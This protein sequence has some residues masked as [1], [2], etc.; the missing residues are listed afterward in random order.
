MKYQLDAQETFIEDS[1]FPKGQEV[2]SGGLE[3]SRL[4]LQLVSLL[5]S[6]TRSELLDKYISM[7]FDSIYNKLKFDIMQFYIYEILYEMK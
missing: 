2:S 5:L 1:L 3:K 6:R 7:W 4:Q